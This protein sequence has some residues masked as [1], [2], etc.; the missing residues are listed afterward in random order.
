MFGGQDMSKMMK[1]MGMDM[2]EIDADRVVV[3]IGDKKM[4]FEQPQLSKIS[5]QGQDMFQ[6]QG[7][8]TEEKIESGPSDEDVELVMEKTEASREEA[9]KALEENEDV[10]AAVM[11]L[12]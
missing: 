10:A 4:V 9:E 5:V 8:F 6:L 3:E 7:E 12:Q 2:D 1:Q 11:D